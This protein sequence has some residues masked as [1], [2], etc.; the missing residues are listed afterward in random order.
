MCAAEMVPDN[1]FSITSMEIKEKNE[2]FYNA[3]E[4]YMLMQSCKNTVL[5]MNEF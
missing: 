3:Y 5:K 2:E 1:L 4:V